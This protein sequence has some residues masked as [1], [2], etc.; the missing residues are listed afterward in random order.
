MVLIAFNS[1]FFAA[2]ILPFSLEKYRVS[3]NKK[4]KNHPIINIV[5]GGRG[6]LACCPNFFVR[7]CSFHG[8]LDVHYIFCVLDPCGNEKELSDCL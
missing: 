6:E 5:S 2:G 7:D 4:E 8:V 3:S 1:Q